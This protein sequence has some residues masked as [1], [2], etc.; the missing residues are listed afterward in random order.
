MTCDCG[1]HFEP[2]ASGDGGCACKRKDTRCPYCV[3]ANEPD[4][5]AAAVEKMVAFKKGGASAMSAFQRAVEV[6]KGYV[7]EGRATS[8]SKALGLVWDESPS[9]REEA[10]S[11]PQPV[12]LRK[13]PAIVPGSSP[14]W[15]AVVAQAKKLVDESDGTL[16]LSQAID[17]VWRSDPS[18]WAKHQAERR[19]ARTA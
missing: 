9:L 11:E 10:Q 5:P 1:A 19:A 16:T 13:K 7:K 3:A 8:L 17:Q 15:L 14:T 6:A 12:P 4:C 2:I 18:L